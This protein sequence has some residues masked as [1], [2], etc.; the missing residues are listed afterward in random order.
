MQSLDILLGIHERKKED[1]QRL[2]QRF[3]NDYI[4]CIQWP[5]LFYAKDEVAAELIRNWLFDHQY[6]DELPPKRSLKYSVVGCVSTP[7]YQ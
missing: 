4:P 6:I 5:A 7:Y 2:G 3:I 1:H